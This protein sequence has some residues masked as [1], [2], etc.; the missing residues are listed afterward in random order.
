M[1]RKW[2]SLPPKHVGLRFYRAGVTMDELLHHSQ[3]V[4][5]GGG[6]PISSATCHS[7][8]I[9]PT[10]AEAICN[11]GCFL[12]EVGTDAIKLE[13]GR[14]MAD[15]VRAIMDAGMTVM[16]HTGLTSQSAMQL[17]GY[18]VQGK[19][20]ADAE[21][22]LGDFEAEGRWGR[23]HAPVAR[24]YAPCRSSAS[25]L[26]DDLHQH[27]LPPPAVE[28]AVEDLLPRA[29]VQ[30]A[31]GDR[32]DHLAAH[33]LALHVRVGVVLAGAVVPVAADRLVRRQLLQPASRS[34]GAAR[35]R[36]R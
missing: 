4:R 2:T 24:R 27:A 8:P 5:R 9:R 23:R 36:R 22:L 29:E 16:G 28:L 20:P 33:D 11:A 18:R 31:V 14:Q 35:T 30:P 26:P 1:T 17:G 34:R 32:H 15:T 6:A 13:G 10:R 25:L 21:H 12:K 7:S 19:T 3:T